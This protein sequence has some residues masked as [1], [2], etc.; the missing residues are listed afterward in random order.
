MEEIAKLLVQMHAADEPQDE[1]MLHSQLTRKRAKGTTIEATGSKK[2]KAAMENPSTGTS[3]HVPH[4]TRAT[5]LSPPRGLPAS[6]ASN[7]QPPSVDLHEIDANFS[8]QL[9]ELELMIPSENLP[10]WE[11]IAKFSKLQ[12]DPVTPGGLK[13]D[14][15]FAEGTQCQ[16]K[17][18]VGD[19]MTENPRK[20]ITKFLGFFLVCAGTQML[21]H[22]A[23]ASEARR[24]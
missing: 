17:V 15:L 1:L 24:V 4:L 5:E 13:F 12:A 8:S 14:E 18:L 7:L 23:S 19:P 2:S 20:I 3:G 16:L 21:P 9:G 6:F 11:N 10:S 22:S